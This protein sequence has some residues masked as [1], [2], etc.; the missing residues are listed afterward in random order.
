MSEEKEDC[1]NAFK[2]PSCPY[3][4]EIKQCSNDIKE[5]KEALLGKDLQNPGLIA[6]FVKLK[7]WINGLSPILKGILI[8]L[9]GFIIEQII[10]HGV[11]RQ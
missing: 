3:L 11:L 10:V 9:I 4:S 8:T 7:S 5:I 2:N 1:E 6:E